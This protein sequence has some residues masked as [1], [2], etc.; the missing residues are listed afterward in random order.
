MGKHNYS[1][2]APMTT[3]EK[4]MRD[5]QAAS[6]RQLLY[7]AAVFYETTPT[8]RTVK[9]KDAKNTG[10]VAASKVQAAMRGFVARRD[11]AALKVAVA[12][13][14]KEAAAAAVD[15]RVKAE[16][17]S[18]LAKLMTGQ[19]LD[20]AAVVRGDMKALDTMHGP[21]TSTIARAMRAF[22]RK[23]AALK[24][25]QR[26][27]VEWYLRRAAAE[28]DIETLMAEGAAKKAA[29]GAA[30]KAAVQ[31]ERAKSLAPLCA[32]AR[33]NALRTQEIGRLSEHVDRL[34]D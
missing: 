33:S 18:S 25:V 21:A 30:K 7:K 34:S 22:M 8:V 20:A 28:A 4:Q 2:M 27:R 26:R 24:E 13:S 6:V 31:E 1:K 3:V 16:L 32:H 29:E 15:R 17:E 14:K 10:A 12:A 5:A 9:I 19:R 11:V 23:Q